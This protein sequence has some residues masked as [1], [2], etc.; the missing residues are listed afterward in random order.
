M[1][2]TNL[3]NIQTLAEFLKIPKATLYFYSQQG[4]IPFLKVG[5]HLRFD[6]HEV[7]AHLQRTR[8]KSAKTCQAPP[9]EDRQSSGRSLKIRSMGQESLR[10]EGDHGN[11]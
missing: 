3:I 11:L 8:T 9:D 2:A 6:A 10:K 4:L 7:L 5:R 1:V